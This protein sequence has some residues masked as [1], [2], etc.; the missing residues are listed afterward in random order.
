MATLYKDTR[1]V[2][3]VQFFDTLNIR[4]SFRLP[5]GT[6]RKDA[7]QARIRIERLIA[8]K[9]LGTIPDDETN[10]W[11]NE[12]GVSLHEKL[13]DHG[14]V[15][16][17]ASLTLGPFLDTY[18]SDR[19]DVKPATQTFY[20]H[21]KRNLIEFFGEGTNLSTIT[22]GDADRWRLNLLGQG[23]A[24]ST[25]RR[26]CGLAKQFFRAALRLKLVSENP[27]EE[28]KACVPANR[29]RDYF[30]SVEEAQK[31]IEACPDAQWRLIFALSR[32]G[33][34][35]CPS[36]H[37][38]LRWED[39]DWVNQKILVHSPKTEHHPNGE[40]RLIPLFPELRE[41]LEDARELAEPD[42]EFA[43]TR[44]R[45]TNANLRTRL[46]RI[47]KRAG[48]EPWPKLFQNLRATRQTELTERFPAHVV[49]AWIGNSKAVADKHYLQVTDDHFSKALE[50]KCAA[51]SLQQHDVLEY[52]ASQTDDSPAEADSP[53]IDKRVS[54][55]EFATTREE[56]PFGDENLQ[57]AGV[58]DRRL[59][60]LTPSL[61]S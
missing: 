33:G 40:S 4:Q 15:P 9:I 38:S 35:R 39:I 50:K 2:F 14:L 31:V 12:L 57:M 51:Y 23:L 56:M 61:S 19:K 48:L 8:A 17:R 7:D 34:L 36:E 10:R 47:I 6:I 55:Q 28:L 32:Y 44:Y 21:T 22:K 60:L 46:L 54:L 5:R 52:N 26:R 45:Q 53:T 27:F 24:E 3:T 20:Q 41:Y 16:P 58:G 43:I 29:K 49:C 1:G 13:S 30:V 18:L 59:E 42:T 11:V 37:L 25:I